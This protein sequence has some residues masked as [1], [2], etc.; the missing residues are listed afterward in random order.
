MNMEIPKINNTPSINSSNEILQ[1]KEITV[2]EVNTEI[3]AGLQMMQVGGNIDAEMDTVKSILSK[4]H[5]GEVTPKQALADFNHMRA[6]RSGA[7][8]G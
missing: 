1:G 7:Y 4:M 2:A 8:N 3:M 5:T 6:S